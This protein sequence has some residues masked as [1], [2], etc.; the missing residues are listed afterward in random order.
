MRLWYR[1]VR[2]ADAPS[3]FRD[4]RLQDSCIL[5]TQGKL[6]YGATRSVRRNPQAAIV[7]LDD[8]AANRQPHTHTI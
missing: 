1:S 4:L 5:G 6:K 2:D 7:R 3:G 8:R